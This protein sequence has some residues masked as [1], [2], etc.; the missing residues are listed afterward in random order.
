MAGCPG[1]LRFPKVAG[2]FL[3]AVVR[4]SSVQE[5][6]CNRTR[7]CPP[8]ERPLPVLLTPIHSERARFE[9]PG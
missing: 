9:D 1:R 4:W 6:L 5:C 8:R 2:C 7:R 3:E